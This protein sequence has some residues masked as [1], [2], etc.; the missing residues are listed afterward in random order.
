MQGRCTLKIGANITG[1]RNAKIV[2]AIN[3][4]YK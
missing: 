3:F 1:T 4:G 2:G